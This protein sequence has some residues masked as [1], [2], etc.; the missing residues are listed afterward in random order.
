LPQAP[1]R[2]PA[3]YVNLKRLSLRHKIGAGG[4][5]RWFWNILGQRFRLRHKPARHL[6][7]GP[8]PPVAQSLCKRI[9][10]GYRARVIRLAMW[11]SVQ[12]WATID[13]RGKFSDHFLPFAVLAL[14]RNALAEGA[15]ALPGFLIFSF[16]PSAMRSRF[17]LILA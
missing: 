13:Q 3:I 4:L 16:D 6:I 1:L 11:A 10:G 2:P 5:G 7:K 15:P 8:M 12:A 17:A 9:W 14:W